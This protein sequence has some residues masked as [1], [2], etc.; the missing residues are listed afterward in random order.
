MNERDKILVNKVKPQ[1]GAWFQIPP[2]STHDLDFS[3]NEKKD[4]EMRK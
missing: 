1:I 2:T 4:F 3:T